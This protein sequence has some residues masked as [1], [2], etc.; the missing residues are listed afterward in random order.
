MK[1]EIF[2]KE[3]ENIKENQTELKNTIT[4]M[5]NIPEEI[6]NRLNDAEEWTCELEVRVVEIT[7]AEQKEEK[8][9]KINED[10][11]R[12]LQD[13]IKCTIIHIIGVPEG[14]E[15]EGKGQRTHLK[16]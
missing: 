2:N 5:R 6:N 3:L 15:R 16:T 4:K 9:I 10:S 13:N 12:N 7:Q 11:L 1:S 14:K 8:R